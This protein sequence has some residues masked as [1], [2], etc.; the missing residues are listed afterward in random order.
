[1]VYAFGVE[2]ISREAPSEPGRQL[3]AEFP[4][5]SLDQLTREGGEVDLLLGADVLGLH[6]RPRHVVGNKWVMELRFG[7][8]AFLMG[9]VPGTATREMNANA[10]RLSKGSWELPLGAK[11][12]HILVERPDFEEFEDLA[13]RQIRSCRG[14][15]GALPY[16]PECSFWGAQ[17]TL[18]EQDSVSWMQ[19]NMH[20]DP[21]ARVIRV[22]YPLR[23][24]AAEQ[25]NNFHQ[26]RRIQEK[27]EARIRKEGLKERYDE[28]MRKMVATGSVRRLEKKEMEEWGGGIHYLPHFGV[29]NPESSS[30]SL[31]IVMDSK[32]KNGSSGLAFND[33]IR[34]V[35]NA[36]NDITDVQLRW[37][38]LPLSLSYDL[39][40]AY[41][42]LVTGEVELHL[43]RFLY[44][45]APSEPW[46]INGCTVVAFGDRPA[47]LALELAATA[48]WTMSGEGAPRRMWRG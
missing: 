30:T 16:C 22:R 45:F 38:C 27:V 2:S 42:A 9:A 41:H 35:P 40:K 23:P 24:E 31:R 19:S 8:G 43:R 33:L 14:C 10:V 28:E 48:T 37:R 36:L 1:M 6:P 46:E 13:A 17:L 18:E 12:H 47:A 5:L 34:A 20:H 39:S 32:C 4:E 11:I 25:P 15:A 21:E 7:S 44:R 3:R 29:H 26:V